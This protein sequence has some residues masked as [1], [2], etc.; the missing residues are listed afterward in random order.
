VR[1]LLSCLQ[2]RSRQAVAFFDEAERHAGQ[3]DARFWQADACLERG[4]ALFDSE[5][6]ASSAARAALERALALFRACG[7]RPREQHTLEALD[8]WFG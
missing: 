3:L 7:A 8:R 5:G 6:R 4:L 1:G 2:G